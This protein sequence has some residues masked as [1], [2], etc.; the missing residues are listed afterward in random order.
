MWDPGIPGFGSGCG[1]LE[2]R[3]LEAWPVLVEGQLGP[4]E[5]PPFLLVTL[6]FWYIIS[7]WEQGL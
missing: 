4:E 2:P 5:A 6:I 3:W 1:V 7:L